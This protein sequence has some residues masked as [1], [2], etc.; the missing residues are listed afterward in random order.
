MTTIPKVVV[1]GIVT[2]AMGVGIHEF[3]EASTLR[4]EIGTL[5]QNQA[6]LVAQI[7]QLQRGRD[8]AARQVAAL[9]DST[10]RLKDNTSELLR[11][12]GEVSVLHSEKRA[13][14]TQQSSSG[15]MTP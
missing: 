14:T 6:R 10:G 8:D 4:N 3:H 11:L 7:E 5:Q 15:S 2:L 13:L 1:G 12:R 9:H